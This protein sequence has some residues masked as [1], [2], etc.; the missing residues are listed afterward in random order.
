MATRAAGFAWLWVLL[1]AKCLLTAS[2]DGW[3][4]KSGVSHSWQSV[5]SDTGLVLPLFGKAVPEQERER[6]SAKNGA[7]TRVSPA[8]PPR[9]SSRS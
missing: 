8:S 5:V 1:H 6:R 9:S 4:R 2:D 3:K 7:T